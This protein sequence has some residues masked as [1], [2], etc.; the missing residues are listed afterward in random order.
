MGYLVV[1]HVSGRQFFVGESSPFVQTQ[2]SGSVS[3]CYEVE[4]LVGSKASGSA[5]KNSS[6]ISGGSS[7]RSSPG[8]ADGSEDSDEEEEEQR[9]VMFEGRLLRYHP[10]RPMAL[11]TCRISAL[12]LEAQWQ[13]SELGELSGEDPVKEMAA[14]Q[15]LQGQQSH[16]SNVEELEEAMTDDTTLYKVTPWYE[17]GELFDLAP[18]PEDSAKNVFAQIL[19][20]L[21]FVHARGVCHRDVSLENILMDTRIPARGSASRSS[22]VS[23]IGSCMSVASSTASDLDGDDGSGGDGAFMDGVCISNPATLDTS[24]A[25]GAEMEPEE[26]RAAEAGEWIGRPRL[27]DFGMSVRIPKS[28][29]KGDKTLITPQGRC[30]KSTCVAPEVFYD[31]AFDAHAVDTWSLGTTLFMALLGVQPWEE[32]GD[33]KFQA[34]AEG[35]NLDVVL[36]GWKLRDAISDEAVDLLQAMLTA[37]PEERLSDITSIL[38]HPWFQR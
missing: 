27:C 19:D 17:G 1:S 36:E 37:D 16:H 38:A 30:G 22:S 3:K 8:G 9:V 32:V 2:F 6:S 29:G 4:P 18:M 15:L 21:K 7:S 23:S 24:C 14:L 25:A 10:S 28:S 20:A 13:Q 12:K 31:Q 26:R 35:K 34:I 5:S 11:K 33:Y